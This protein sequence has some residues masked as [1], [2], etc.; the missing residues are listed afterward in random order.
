MTLK[1]YKEKLDKHDWFYMMSGD[2]RIYDSGLV[3]DKEILKLALENETFMKAYR[4]KH[5]QMFPSKLRTH[6]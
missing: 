3:K 1:E 4:A 5:R 2:S 6:K